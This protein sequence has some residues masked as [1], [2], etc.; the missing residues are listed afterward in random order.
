LLLLNFFESLIFLLIEI[1]REQEEKEEKMINNDDESENFLDG[2]L[3]LV[4]KLTSFDSSKA[5][6]KLFFVE[7]HHCGYIF[8]RY[9]DLLR[10]FPDVF[11]FDDTNN[12]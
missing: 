4:N 3:N 9:F 6:T 1:F 11:T 7:Q 12:K 2:I 8:P 10:Q 5:S